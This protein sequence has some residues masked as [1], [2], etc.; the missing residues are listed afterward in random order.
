MDKVQPE[1]TQEQ[2]LTKAGQLPA[3]LP[4]FLRYLACLALANPSATFY[5]LRTH[6]RPKYFA[7][8]IPDLVLT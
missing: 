4:G 1:V 2:L 8:C 5:L 3:R 7:G 6:G